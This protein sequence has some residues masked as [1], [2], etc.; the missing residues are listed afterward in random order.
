[1]KNFGYFILILLMSVSL[2]AT[3]LDLGNSIFYNN[4]GS[5]NLVVDAGVAVRNLDSP[6]VLFVLYMSADKKISAHINRE[7][8]VLVY[9]DQEYVM[10][11]LAEF[12]KNYN[13]DSRDHQIYSRLGKESLFLSD[14]RYFLFNR[15]YDFFP[16]KASGILP[17]DNGYISSN[18]GFKSKAYFKNPGFKSG[19]SVVIK[20]RDKNNPEIWG[21]V[22]V[23]LPSQ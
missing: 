9:N 13:S 10:P 6:Y 16:V 2:M 3:S 15:F 8:V 12:R 14:M 7:D 21:S 23:E 11:D 20:V 4:E 19:D 17:V 18:F 1:M 22:V 5:I